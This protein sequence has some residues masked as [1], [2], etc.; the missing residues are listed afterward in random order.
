MGGLSS[1]AQ[2]LL[3]LELLLELLLLLLLLLM[4]AFTHVLPR[5]Y[6]APP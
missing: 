1:Q 3:L 6:E 5:G 2:I 4:H